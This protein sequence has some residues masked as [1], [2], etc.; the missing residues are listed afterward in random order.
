MNEQIAVNIKQRIIGALVLVSLGVILIPLLLNG[1]PDT[2]ASFPDKNIPAMPK[3]LTKVLP[4]VPQAMT[5]PAPKKI[6]SRPQRKLVKDAESSNKKT[7][8]KKIIA[9]ADTQYEKA[10]KPDNAKITSA[11]TIQI[12]S[13]SEKTNAT[14]LQKKLRKKKFKAYIESILT[15][16]GRMYRLRVGP[17]LKFEQISSIQKQI[18]TKF[19][20]NN[21][22]IVKYKTE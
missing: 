18:E 21:T 22:I 10:G 9:V 6:I 12:A 2:D 11:Y 1:G 4:D 8:A 13:F 3:K 15:S 20:L 19:K 7:T 17:Y 16:K 5:M 14:T